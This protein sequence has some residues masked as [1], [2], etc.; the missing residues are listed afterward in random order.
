MCIT[1]STHLILYFNA[2]LI[3]GKEYK[4][5]NSC[6]A[7][8]SILLLLPVSWSKYCH[9]HLFPSVCVLTSV[10]EAM[11]NVHAKQEAKS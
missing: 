4:L 5:L 3:F 11:F 2:K 1:Y 6:Y 9:Q 8:F 10:R 7:V